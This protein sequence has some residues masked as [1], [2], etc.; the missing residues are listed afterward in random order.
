M[1]NSSEYGRSYYDNTPD[2]NRIEVLRRDLLSSKKEVID[3]RN[4]LAL[5][6]SITKWFRIFNGTGADHGSRN[7]ELCQNEKRKRDGHHGC[8]GCVV[9]K[10]TNR[11]GCN[12]TPYT[13]WITHHDKAHGNANGGDEGRKVE[14]GECLV[15]AQREIN[16]LEGLKPKVVLQP[17]MKFT[18]GTVN[19][20]VGH[21]PPSPY[22]Q[23]IE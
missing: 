3:I 10:D 8:N 6:K 19:W 2:Q 11:Y 21:R 13:D 12:D 18:A 17:K 7:C 9:Y 16:Y 20:N 4:D 15:I 5:E 14:C 23:T 1:S 22:F